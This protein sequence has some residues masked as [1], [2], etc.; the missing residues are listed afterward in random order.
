MNLASPW[1]GQL[2]Q[3]ALSEPPQLVLQFFS[4]GI[5]MRKALDN[6]G[7]C[8]YP[9]DAAHIAQAL[10]AKVRFDTG[11]LG[12]DVLLVRREGLRELVAGYRCPQM[13][14][15]WLE[16]STEPVRVPLPG[17]VL[18]RLKTGNSFQFQLFAV[19]RRPTAM[20]VSLYNAPLPNVYSS[21]GICWGNIA[22]ADSNG[23]SLTA[24]W[25][26]LLGTPFGNLSVGGKSQ[27]HRHDIRDLL[28]K[29]AAEGK[30]RYPTRDLVAVQKTLG[31]V[32]DWG[33]RDD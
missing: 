24:D 15:I 17:L 12:S 31:Q 13:T 23:T 7:Y 33:Q 9:V 27:Q 1:S 16:G 21:G 18:L 19:K 20:T 28:L 25:Q 32:T 8:E 11:L 6:G 2:L 3:T 5:L 22:H 4:Y 10:A 26:R 29:L 30:R 14:G